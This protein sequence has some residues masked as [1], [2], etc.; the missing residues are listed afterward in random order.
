M[1]RKVVKW[2]NVFEWA[3]RIIAKEGPGEIYLLVWEDLN[4]TLLA[5][6]EISSTGKT[7]NGNKSGNYIT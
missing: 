2:G 1:E 3:E 6:L 5:H 7:V 4:I